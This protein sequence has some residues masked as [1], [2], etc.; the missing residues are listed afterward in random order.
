MFSQEFIFP[1][2]K[3]TTQDDMFDFLHSILQDKDCVYPEYLEKIKKREQ[4]FPTGLQLSQIGIAMP[5][6]E[7][8]YAKKNTFVVMTS[9]N[10]IPFYNMENSSPMVAKVI[11][12][13]VFDNR[14]RHMDNL[15]TLSNIIQNEELLID[16]CKCTTSEE[17]YKLIQKH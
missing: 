7:S 12:A 4:N 5:H 1:N 10:G 14:D 15:Q 6:T 16:I 17:I 2:I 8:T 3:A 13:I 11:F 9:E